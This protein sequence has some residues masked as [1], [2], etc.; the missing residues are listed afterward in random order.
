MSGTRCVWRGGEWMRELGLGFTIP[1]G[2]V[3]HASVF[4]LRCCRW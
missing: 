4:W 1:M 3:G 2:S